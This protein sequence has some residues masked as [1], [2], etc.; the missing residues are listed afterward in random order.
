[1]AQWLL[2]CRDAV[3]SDEFTLT[4]EFMATMLGVRRATVSVTAGTLQSAGLISYK[5]GRVK[6]LDAAGLGEAACE[7]YRAIRDA[8]DSPKS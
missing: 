5:H 6:V 2:R 4:H 8:F 3:G 1:M 7:C